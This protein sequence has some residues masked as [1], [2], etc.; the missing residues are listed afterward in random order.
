M[1][2]VW[3]KVINERMEEY[4]VQFLA[5]EMFSFVREKK[6][7]EEEVNPYREKQKRKGQ[8]NEMKIRRTCHE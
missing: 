2:C 4:M 3:M 6:E 8:A 1:A 5:H 7:E